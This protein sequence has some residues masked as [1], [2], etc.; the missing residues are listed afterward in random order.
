MNHTDRTR[1]RVKLTK[2]IGT[3]AS[4]HSASLPEPAPS[5]LCLIL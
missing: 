2:T 1:N 3:L 4:H 5:N